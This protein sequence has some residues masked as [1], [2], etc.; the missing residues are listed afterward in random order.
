MADM[1]NDM[2]LSVLLCDTADEVTRLRHE[3]LV[4]AP[5][6]EVDATVDAFRA[7]ETAARTRPDVIVCS[8]G[9][10]GL[11]GRAFI[12]RLTDSSPASA[13]VVIG[14]EP[15]PAQVASALAAGAVGFVGSGEPAAAIARAV[16]SA[17][18]GG[19]ALSTAS[20]TRLAIELDEAFARV[21]SVEAQLA[22]VRATID[23]GTAAK[24]DFLANISHELR[25][26]VT[27]AKGIAYVL[28]NPSV[29]EHERGEFL[30]QLQASLDKLMTLVDEIITIA[31]LERGTFELRLEPV[32]LAPVVRHAVDEVR[33]RYPT[34]EVLDEIAAEL[35]S[36]ADGTRIAGVV[37]ELLDNACRYSPPGAP[38][39]LSA[40]SLSEGVV[41]AVIDRGEGLDRAIAAKSFEE[42]FT[43]GE[44]TLRKEKAGVGVGLHLARQM[45]VEHGGILWTDP[46]PGGGTRAAFCIPVRGDRPATP[47]AAGVA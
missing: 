28:K 9:L 18:I 12:R 45:I 46:L 40:R 34:V 38:V 20:A 31:E 15:D 10:E 19:V 25:T 14:D 2:S 22:E 39:E 13:V 41:V 43:T 24:A 4:A 3:L 47:P 1:G 29:P 11:G 23:R 35:P 17:A 8:L 21:D 27:V 44:G 33:G 6:I 37:R 7:V 16:R 26:P 36:V 5:D 32:D 30:Q 42:P